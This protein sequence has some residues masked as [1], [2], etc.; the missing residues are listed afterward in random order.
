MI[1]IRNNKKSE[2]HAGL[3][4][5]VYGLCKVLP[6]ALSCI[7]SL[8]NPGQFLGWGFFFG[9]LVCLSGGGL[10]PPSTFIPVVN[11]THLYKLPP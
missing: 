6:L 3:R 10:W 11:P 7:P 1:G 5:M 8:K 9:Y 2:L 4:S